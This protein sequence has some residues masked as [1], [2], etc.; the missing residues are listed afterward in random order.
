M[1]KVDYEARTPI[2]T[3]K[4]FTFFRIEGTKRWR[5]VFS[6]VKVNATLITFH[7]QKKGNKNDTIFLDTS[8]N[9]VLCPV[10]YWRY[11]LSNINKD[12]NTPVNTFKHKSLTWIITVLEIKSVLQDIV[13]QIGEEKLGVMIDDV[14]CR[15]IRTSLSLRLCL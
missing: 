15:N 6:D 3:R 4:Y 2:L 14:M 9:D 5:T 1:S 11:V 8:E 13:R 12:P 10:K 7:F